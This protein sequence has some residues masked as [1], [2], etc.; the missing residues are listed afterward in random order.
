M[1]E[2]RPPATLDL[3]AWVRRAASNP[4]LHRQRQVTEILLYAVAITPGFGSELFLK[5]G[6]LMAIAYGSPRNTGDV[7]FTAI[8]DPEEVRRRVAAA[9][10]SSFREAAVRTGHP[11]ILC[12][13]QRVRARPRPETFA[14]SPIAALQITI[15][16]AERSNPSEVTRLEAGEATQ[17]V[18][19]DLSFHEPIGS[20]QKLVLGG[21]REVQAYGL[22]DL[23]AEKLRAIL[24]Q[25]VR[26]HPGTRRQD[27]YDI[28]RLVETFGL[29]APERA[30]ILDILLRKSHEREFDPTREMIADPRIE[31]KLR[32]DWPTLANEL[33]EQLPDFDACFATVRGFY[34]S[35]PWT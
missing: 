7:D 16:S 34:E 11:N 27:V 25:V 1:L 6:V 10:D 12:R 29:D 9:L 13:V 4:V 30:A 22:Y 19:I 8:G 5:G 32:A 33:D 14:S 2:P 26:P 15:G 3:T 28:A 23:V 20:V 31:A 21:G 17:V 35:L 24:Q 18:R